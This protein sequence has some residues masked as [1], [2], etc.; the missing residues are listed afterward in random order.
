MVDKGE[1]EMIPKRI[2]YVW[3]GGKPLPAK[4]KMNIASWKR[5]NPDYDIIE[6]NEE[7]YNIEN[8]Q[9]VESAYKNGQWAFASDYARL[10]VVYQHGGFYL[11]TDVKLLKSLEPLRSNKSVW[12]ME[13]SGWV[14][15]GLI[16]GA[17][18]DDDDLRKILF[19]YDQ[20][21]FDTNDLNS[22]ITTTILSDY[23]KVQGLKKKNK[24]QTLANGTKVYP[25]QYFAPFHWWGGGKITRKTI[26]VHQ[27]DKQ[28]GT[29]IKVGK[30]KKIKFTLLLYF[31]A[32]YNLI[33]KS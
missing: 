15:S 4:V 9:F 10:D 19:K 7:N 33:F 1:G 25:S 30:K 6:I 31:P 11:D 3:F 5:W 14:N 20:L 21:R 26:A 29:K 2:Y 24:L 18:K 27:Y 16:I 13:N 22:V 8:H 17:Q 32:L 23:F 12:G 28:W